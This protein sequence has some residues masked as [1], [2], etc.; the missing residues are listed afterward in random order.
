MNS[1]EDTMIELKTKKSVSKFLGFAL[2]AMLSF[3][4]YASSNIIEDQ[5][6]SMTQAQKLVQNAQIKSEF[7]IVF[8]ELVLKE[9]NHYLATLGG[10][11]YLRKSFIRMEQFRPMVMRKLQQFQLPKELI[12][13]P[14]IESGYQNL[15]QN[16]NKS[17]G[18]GLWMFIKS[19]ARNYGLT[20]NT[21]TD[22]RLNP[23][24]LTDAAM[25]YILANYFRFK[26]YQLAM[27]SY[28]IGENKGQEGINKLKTRDAWILARNGYGG[29]QYLARL[30]AVITILKNPELLN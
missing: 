16:E 28:N 11:D 12:T 24:I 15:P 17:W 14:I 19:T 29:E 5:R 13:V 18:A 25:R 30:M 10:K 6:V 26:D 2:T 9:L 7:P 1:Q 8:N 4:A 20:V 21:S 23:E 22:E 3:T 27:L